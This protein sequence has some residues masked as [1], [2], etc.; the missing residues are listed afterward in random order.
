MDFNSGGRQ[1]IERLVKAYG[2][3]T[4]QALSDHLGVS[5]STL[6][7]R[8]MR[9]IFPSDWIIQ[10]AMETG[11]SLEWLVT[12]TGEGAGNTTPIHQRPANDNAL[13]DVTAIACK[14][15]ID[16]GIFDSNFLMLD[17]AMIPESILKPLIILKNETSYLAENE[18]SE[19]TDGLWVIDIEGKISIRTL[20]RVPVGKV[21]VNNEQSS[22]ECMLNEIKPIAKCVFKLLADVE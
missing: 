9:D 5:K 15:I 13:K 7:T 3:S 10:C 19:I 18:F 16:G 1:A 17:K 21:Q 20:V 12:G 2:F 22:F 14:K 6:A 11:V 4:R 8:Y